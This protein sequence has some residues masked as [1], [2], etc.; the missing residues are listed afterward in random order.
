MQNGA[1]KFK[2]DKHCI[3]ITG[4]NIQG[5]KSF[6]CLK[7]QTGA[8]VVMENFESNEQMYIKVANGDSYDVIVPSDYMIERLISEDLLQKLDKSKLNCMDL[9][10][11]GVK[12]FPYMIQTM[13]ILFH[14]SGE[15]LELFMTKQKWIS[16]IW[17]RRVQYLP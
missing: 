16:K 10:S 17:K 1:G 13:I 9:L 8:K 15:R 11:D 12:G 2:K 7:K 5:R 14:I 4:E 3:Y 6:L